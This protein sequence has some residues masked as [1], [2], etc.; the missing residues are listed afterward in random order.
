LLLPLPIVESQQ[1]YDIERDV[2]ARWDHDELFPRGQAIEFMRQTIRNNPGEVVLLAIAPLTNVAL[3]FAA[4]PDIPRLL[5][6]LV[7]MAGVFTHAIPSAGLREWNALLDPHA[8]AMVYRAG[9][10]THRSVGLDVTH[11][12]IFDA[13][14]LIEWPGRRSNPE[15]LFCCVVR[16]GTLWVPRD[17]TES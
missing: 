1:P 16:P 10:R 14:V 6:G 4:D 7:M 17:A 13:I 15:S 9:A 2:L 5:K 11:D 3:L 8:T 12:T